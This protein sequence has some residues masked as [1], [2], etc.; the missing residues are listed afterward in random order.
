MLSQLTIIIPVYNE[1]EAIPLV[2]PEILAE[3]K[4]QNMKVIAVDDGS[5]DESVDLLNDLAKKSNGH[6]RVIHHKVNKGYGGALKTG[7]CETDTPYL[8]TMDADGQHSIQIA[9]SILHFAI[10]HDADLVVGNRGKASSGWFRDFGKFLIRTFANIIVP[11]KN[12][13]LNSGYKL[14]KTDLAKRYIC[15]CPDG[16]ALSDIM[17]MTFLYQ[18][19]LVLDY[20][21][22]IQ[23]RIAGKSTISYRTAVETL[24]QILNIMM[25]FNPLKFF[26]P[27]SFFCVLLGFLWGIPFALQGRGVSVGAMLS[28]T[29]GWLLFALGLMAHQLSEIRQ[30]SLRE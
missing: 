21:I 1:Q 20:P 29:I 9:K 14:Y 13:D 4:R 30:S 6:F 25:L 12:I 28:I 8:L 24:I 10:E 23:N 3:S 19:N 11:L 7:I 26:L 18:K 5:K 17:T 16:M 15:I 2:F 27:S 22:S